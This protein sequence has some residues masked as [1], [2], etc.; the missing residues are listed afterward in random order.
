MSVQS[1]LVDGMAP[2]YVAHA[3]SSD[4]RDMH[5]ECG[6]EGES[7]LGLDEGARQARHAWLLAGG[8]WEAERAS[9][10]AA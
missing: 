5:G 1:H 10:L 9:F 7:G 8:G 6:C 3:C 4:S 2:M